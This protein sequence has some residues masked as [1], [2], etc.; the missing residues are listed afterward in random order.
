MAEQKPGAGNDDELLANAIP[1]DDL[2]DDVLEAEEVD[3]QDVDAIEMEDDDGEEIDLSAPVT[4][5]KEIRKFDHHREHTENWKRP[6]NKDGTGA[7]HVRTFVSKLR[8]DAIEHLEEQVNEWLDNHPD[9]EVK[10]VTSSVGV[11]TGK[12]QEEAMFLTVWV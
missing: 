3:E 10:H 11:L 5:G 12:L 1:I 8:L 9:Y 7:T 6:T 2:S 4:G